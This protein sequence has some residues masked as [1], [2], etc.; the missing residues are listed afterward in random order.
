MENKPASENAQTTAEAYWAKCEDF[1]DLGAAE[2][3]K[4]WDA[5]SSAATVEYSSE[6]APCCFWTFADG[7]DLAYHECAEGNGWE[8]T[9]GTDFQAIPV[10][11][12]P[13]AIAHFSAILDY[14]D[15]E[16]NP[17]CLPEVQ[18]G[19]DL[20]TPHAIRI[21][22]GSDKHRPAMAGA[23]P[24]CE[25]RFATKELLDAFIQGVDAAEGYLGYK[26]VE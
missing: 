3:L 1:G 7:S 16:D 22:W 4:P 25:Y 12:T 2:K 5:I 21:L 15:G 9:G 13:A 23:D 17:D 26:V 19:E 8:E 20:A 24:I 14:R 18:I 6:E 10:D 11:E